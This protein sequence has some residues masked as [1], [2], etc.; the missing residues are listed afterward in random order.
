MWGRNVV[1]AVQ[2]P[3]APQKLPWFIL[4]VFDA[5][6]I[7]S[8]DHLGVFLA[9]V[10]K[11]CLNI[12]QLLGT[13]GQNNS[14][15]STNGTADVGQSIQVLKVTYP[16]GLYGGGCNSESKTHITCGLLA[17]GSVL[18]GGPPGQQRKGYDR[19]ERPCK[20]AYH[21]REKRWTNCVWPS[22]EK[23]C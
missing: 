7:D 16:E 5:Y 1:W 9:I 4:T 8:L 6:E 17:S 15:K 18:P 14:G 21:W 19:G 13:K 12:L 3:K 20:Y 11:S 23:E 22:C 2:Y 10:S